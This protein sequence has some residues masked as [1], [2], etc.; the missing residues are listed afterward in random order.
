M[1]SLDTLRILG[2]TGRLSWISCGFA[3][4]LR[5]D[6]GVTD[7]VTCVGDERSAEG[8]KM[9]LDKLA[10]VGEIVNLVRVGS[11]GSDGDTLITGNSTVEFECVGGCS[12]D[13]MGDSTDLFE[14][15]IHGVA[16][17]FK[18]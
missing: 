17:I 18:N 12:V 15:I 9:G 4:L 10:P 7:G 13:I 6:D 3:W 2:S 14:L 16:F 11:V 1:S 8:I 5:F